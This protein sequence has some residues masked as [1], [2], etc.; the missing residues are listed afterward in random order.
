MNP[1]EDKDAIRPLT[2]EFILGER[3]TRRPRTGLKNGIPILK[4]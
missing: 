4:K 2:N 3:K 1:G